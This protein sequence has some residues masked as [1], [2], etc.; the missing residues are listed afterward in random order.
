[1]TE[2]EWLACTDPRT[3]LEVL[4]GKT[5]DRKSRLFVVACCRRISSFMTDNRSQTAVDVA[6]GFADGLANRRERKAAIEAALAAMKDADAAARKASAAG[7]EKR[8]GSF[9]AAF[10]ALIAVS[11]GGYDPWD[12]ANAAGYAVE[13]LVGTPKDG[14]HV[15]QAALVL[16]IFG[17]PFRPVSIDPAWQT[18]T[19]VALAQAAYDNRTLPAGTFEPAR[20]AVLADALEEAGCDNAD[21]LGH[22]RGPGPHV[23]GCWAVDLLLGKG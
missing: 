13:L 3:M 4:G 2:A 7:G 19:V 16:D 6:E 12:A 22:L 21:L 18:P 9:N 11:R 23:R 5:S 8:W 1:V 10:T 14:E 15:A 20:L 17:N